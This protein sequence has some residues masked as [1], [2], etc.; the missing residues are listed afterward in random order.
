MQRTFN[1]AMHIFT[2]HRHNVA[3]TNCLGMTEWCDSPR[4]AS[5]RLRAWGGGEWEEHTS[6]L[7]SNLVNLIRLEGLP[8]QRLLPYPV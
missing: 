2:L 4:I 5:I 8:S 3:S 7:S 1:K 6:K